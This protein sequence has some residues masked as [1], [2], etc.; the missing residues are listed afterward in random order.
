MSPFE[1]LHH[2]KLRLYV[3][4]LQAYKIREFINWLNNKLI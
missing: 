1:K 4:I 2:A 3:A